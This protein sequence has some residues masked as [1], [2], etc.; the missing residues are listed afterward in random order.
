MDALTE[1]SAFN[2]EAFPLH[3]QN[4]KDRVVFRIEVSPQALANLHGI[5]ER[6]GITQIALTSKLVEWVAD[7]PSEVQAA[8]LISNSFG[9]LKLDE[10]GIAFMKKM[11]SGK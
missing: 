9:D 6:L 2:A 10:P 1:A 8:I 4:G 3:S 5:V 7:Q 11:A